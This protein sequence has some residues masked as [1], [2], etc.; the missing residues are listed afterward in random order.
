MR[1][2]IKIKIAAFSDPAGKMDS[3]SPYC[4]NEDAFLVDDDLTDNRS[5][6]FET[7]RTISLGRYGC[8]FVIADGMG[9]ANAGEIASHLAVDIIKDRFQLGRLE[10]IGVDSN[11]VRIRYLEDTI[12]FADKQIGVKSKEKPEYSGMG[13]TIVAGWLVQ[14][15]LTI[16]WVGD[17]RA[18]LFRKGTLKLLTE[19]HTYVQEL[20][21]KR[22]LRYEETFGHP[23][24]HILTRCLG[25]NKKNEPSIC[26]VKIRQ[27]DIILFC[28]DGLSGVLRDQPTLVSSD[29]VTIERIIN[30]NQHSLSSCRDSLFCNAEKAGWYDNIT[31]ILVKVVEK[32][33]FLWGR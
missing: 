6:H 9:G 12:N 20:V 26:Q 31:L 21:K 11:K 4:G 25:D 33:L 28:S 18:Y 1:K 24:G 27:D 15:I 14:D 10:Q 13:S 5:P 23:Q 3:S 7:D 2:E 8:L 16:C 19:D 30:S 17:S 29:E 32:N 22:E